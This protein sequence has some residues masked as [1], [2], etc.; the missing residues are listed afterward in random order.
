MTYISKR[1]NERED[2]LFIKSYY[3]CS[4]CLFLGWIQTYK[5]NYF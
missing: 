4:Q 1:D 5:Y 3:S 2:W